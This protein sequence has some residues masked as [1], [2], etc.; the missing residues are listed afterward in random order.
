VTEFERFGTI[1]VLA[2]GPSSEREISLESGK[3]V[4]EALKKKGHTALFL[5]IKDELDKDELRRS[6][7]D[8]VFIALHGKYGE[9][10]ALQSALEDMRIPYTGS[11]PCAS[12]L[13]LDKIA[14]RNIFIKN[15][16]DVP[17][18]RIAD[19]NTI[20][21]IRETAV[22]SFGFPLV[23]K[24]QFEGS[25]FG[26]SIVKKAE[27]LKGALDTAFDY[28]D[29][30]IIEEYI[31][32]REITV[33]IL[34]DEP[35][36]VVEIIANENFYD[37]KAKYKSGLTRYVVPAGIDK[38]A[39]DEAMEK[40]KRAHALLGCRSFSR[41]DMIYDEKRQKTYILEVNSIPGLTRHSLLPKAAQCIGIDFGGMC[42]KIVKAAFA[43]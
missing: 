42:L 31:S 16:I 10:G 17:N 18:F 7:C 26:V 19:K 38:K 43:K 35:L 40:G 36:P 3:A 25:S 30:I 9:D 11:G 41:V 34:D 33:G 1:A 22:R 12:K 32:G 8:V 6:G 28:G 14:S 4:V 15:G 39:Q 2:G 29:K 37:F 20:R 27:D 5:D 21:E 24:P 23:M 13:A